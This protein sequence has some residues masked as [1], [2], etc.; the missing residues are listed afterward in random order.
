MSY[1]LLWFII[2]SKTSRQSLLAEPENALRSSVI[3]TKFKISNQ[4][5]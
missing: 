1:A 5:D 4:E 3:P 2:T